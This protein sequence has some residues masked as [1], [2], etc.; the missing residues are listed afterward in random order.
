MHKLNQ[1][2]SYVRVGDAREMKKGEGVSS[3][4]IQ[5]NLTPEKLKSR[6]ATH[7]SHAHK[8][9]YEREGISQ[10]LCIQLCES[11]HEV[12]GERNTQAKKNKFAQNASHLLLPLSTQ[13]IP[14]KR[15]GN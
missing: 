10:F 7:I 1:L 12:E 3:T 14:K 11:F 2:F 4:K 5:R 15:D 8:N 13:H 9:E 6:H